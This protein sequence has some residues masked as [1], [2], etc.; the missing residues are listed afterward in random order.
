MIR[1]SLASLGA[2]LFLVSSLSGCAGGAGVGEAAWPP[3]G[4]KWYER[5]DASFQR[6]DMEDAREAIDNALKVVPDRPEARVLSAKVALASLDYDRVQAA[7]RGI[8]TS[9]ARSLRG[10]AYWYAGDVEHAADELEKLLA[11]PEV[12]DP[13]AT[14]IAKLARLGAGRKPFDVSGSMVGFTEMP[15]AGTSALIVPLDINGE[16]AL[17]LVATGKAEAVIDS[18]G[19]ARASWVSLRFGERLDVRDVP[20]LA[21]DLSGVSRQVNAPIKILLGVNLLRH[22]RPTIDFAGG[23]FVVRAFEPPP[24]PV[25]TTVK[26]SYVRGGGM[27]VRGAFGADQNAQPCSLMIDTTMSFPVALSSDAWKK[28]GVSPASLQPVPGASD[29]RQG[30]VPALR[31]G[32]FDIPRVPGVQ[33]D[34]VVKEREERLGISFDG[35]IGSG[36][37]AGFRVTL[38]DGGRSMWLEDIP[39]EALNAPSLFANLPPIEEAPDAEVPEEAEKPGKGKPGAAPR[40]PASPSGA[41]P[42]PKS[43]VSPSGAAPAPAPK[44]PTAPPGAPKGTK[45]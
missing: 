25:A 20:V 9:E 5:A 43:P 29:L 19:G 7:L 28:A 4:K 10:R 1:Q 22:L 38:V 8:E 41:A 14:E 11:D 12:R 26:L 27:L 13:W 2:T 45:P 42:T 31:L 40:S 37:L 6:G 21:E 34:S 36:L 32:A 24:P 3:L 35:L 17:G 33:G 30:F 23:Q 18:S 15:R 44:S 16:P 39:A